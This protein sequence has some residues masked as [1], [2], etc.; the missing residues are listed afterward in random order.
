MNSVFSRILKALCVAFLI[1]ALFACG[2]GKTVD[3]L[4][5]KRVIGL[6]DAYNDVGYGGPNT[7]FTVRPL[8]APAAGTSV[9]EQFAAILGAGNAGTAVTARTSLSSSGVF[10][11]AQ[12]DTLVLS[13][14]NK[15]ADQVSNAISDVGGTFNSN[16]VIVVTA[17]AGD[18]R[19][20]SLPA[21]IATAVTS[22]V[23]SLL[24]ANAQ[25]VVVMMPIDVAKMHGGQGLAANGATASYIGYLGVD[26][27]NL[28]RTKSRNPVVLLDPALS[29]NL[30]NTTTSGFSDNTLG[31]TPGSVVGYC[32]A[33]VTS[34]CAEVANQTPSYTAM[35]F[36]DDNN[37]T[38]AGN[39]WVANLLYSA[40]GLAGWR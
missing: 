13:G 28:T 4:V 7:R 3:P 40:T 31:V 9:V 10:S 34:G 15:L 16:D 29:F 39:G 23:S 21:D 32:G 26:I 19:A 33:A 14:N 25:Y 12:G 8:V 22:A 30:L 24:A 11:Y 38:P 27:L 17:G 2:S 35:F 18:L 5:A 37:L 20:G 6:G 1:T 36:A